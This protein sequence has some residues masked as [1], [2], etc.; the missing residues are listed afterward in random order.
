MISE[1]LWPCK[2]RKQILDNYI[3]L[4]HLHQNKKSSISI[5]VH[6]RQPV[7]YWRHYQQ[8]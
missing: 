3:E 7:K 2:K 8:S 1:V 5:E 4:Y 6:E